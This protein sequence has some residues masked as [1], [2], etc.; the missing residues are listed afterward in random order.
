L[1]E[2]PEKIVSASR[3]NQHASRVRY[4]DIGRYTPKIDKAA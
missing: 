2:V 4:P 1:V 3:R